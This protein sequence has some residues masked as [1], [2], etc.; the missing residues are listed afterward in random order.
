[1]VG[2][3]SSGRAGALALWLLA[4]VSACGSD[5]D[6]GAGAASSSSSAS[7]TS[8]SGASSDGGSGA[9]AASGTGAGG[10]AGT[11]ASSG[12]GATGGG[13]A[14][15]GGGAGVGGVGGTGAGGVG[16]AGVGGAP[17]GGAGG[18]GT[19]GVASGGAGVG[20]DGGVGA[21]GG[22]GGDTCTGTATS[23]G[24]GGGGGNGSDV[25]VPIAGVTVSTVAGSSMAGSADG[26]AG[27]AQFANPVNLTL[28]ELGNIYVA[29][30][31]N[32]R[33]R[34]I[35]MPLGDVSTLVATG[36][37][38]PFG[39]TLDVSGQ[40]YVQTDGNPTGQLSQTT[41]TIWFVDAAT[42][43]TNPLVANIGRPRGLAALPTGALA[44]ADVVSQTVTT[45][46]P[47]GMTLTPLAGMMGCAG[48]VDAAGTAA[49][50]H[51][52]YGT[53]SLPNG[54]LVLADENNH[55]I[56]LVTTTGVVSTLAGD[57]IPG[58][59]DGPLAGARFAFPTDVDVDAAGNIYVSDT[60]THRI[61]RISIA[62][63]LVETVAGDGQ[64]GFL[65]G[66][67]E[68]AR[69][70]GQEGIAVLADGSAIFVADGTGGLPGEPYH[71]I[72]R[73]VLP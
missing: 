46:D 40:L 34:K 68:T 14:S 48:F 21:S 35:D 29:D 54:D 25:V 20:G 65:D 23:A 44:V 41:G 58:T 57:G 62:T 24:V 55:R 11:G 72:R 22:A 67:G 56:R 2:T 66:P 70:F 52:P 32:S 43:A 5:G 33:V 9:A 17:N 71:R 53:A 4:C 10:G 16:G 18:T 31:D 59:V 1:M 42:G 73:V 3:L 8:G 47:V 69:F 39:I 37:V 50:F 30:F 64:P 51:R 28:D 61:R 7:A 38:R 49:R 19:G 45:L 36:I 6:D 60:G 26:L 63:G 15:V 12:S 27:A 13:G